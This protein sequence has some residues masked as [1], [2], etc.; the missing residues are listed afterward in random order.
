MSEHFRALK[1]GCCP[2]PEMLG[3]AENFSYKII[4]LL[5]QNDNDE[6]KGDEND[7]WKRHFQRQ[8]LKNSSN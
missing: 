2:H 1:I 8:C 5:Y 3:L 6:E 7:T 4:S